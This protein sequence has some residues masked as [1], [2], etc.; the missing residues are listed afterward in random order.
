MSSK[1]EDYDEEDHK[2]HFKRINDRQ[3]KWRHILNKI[4][5]ENGAQTKRIPKETFFLFGKHIP[6]LPLVG[7]LL[8]IALILSYAMSKYAGR[9]RHE[10]SAME[11]LIAEEAPSCSLFDFYCHHIEFSPSNNQQREEEATYNQNALARLEDLKL[12]S[13]FKIL[14]YDDIERGQTGSAF[15]TKL[16]KQLKKAPKAPSTSVLNYSKRSRAIVPTRLSNPCY[17]QDYSSHLGIEALAIFQ[18]LSR[19]LSRIDAPISIDLTQFAKFR[20]LN[21]QQV[22]GKNQKANLTPC[23]DKKDGNESAI[24]EPVEITPY[25]IGLRHSIQY[26]P[27]ILVLSSKSKNMDLVFEEFESACEAQTLANGMTGICEDLYSFFNTRRPKRFN[28]HQW[29]E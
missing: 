6:W 25:N 19:C 14:K 13:R 27:T 28:V 9:R 5:S 21:Q 16:L 4:S 22:E 23:A 20:I 12:S 18:K 2:S 11:K 15:F 24:P 29:W 10:K 26:Q 17:I 8:I 1:I 7:V 3:E